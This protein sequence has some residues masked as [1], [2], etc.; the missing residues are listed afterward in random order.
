MQ[1]KEI[2]KKWLLKVGG[3][4]LQLLLFGS[5][6][7][8]ILN[9]GDVGTT[10][11]AMS[12]NSSKH[13]QTNQYV[14]RFVAILLLVGIAISVYMFWRDWGDGRFREIAPFTV[15]MSLGLALVTFFLACD[16]LGKPI[17]TAKAWR[18]DASFA[19]RI[20]SVFWTRDCPYC[21]TT[22]VLKKKT[23]Y[24]GKDW[25]SLGGGSS[26]GDVYQVRYY[27]ECENCKKEIRKSE[28]LQVGKLRKLS[29]CRKKKKK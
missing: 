1:R 15:V 24:Q 29:A 4:F 18:C 3:F 19:E 8:D 6:R 2:A 27:Y 25:I 22:L 5:V 23:S 11:K 21:Q 9:R 13:A 16:V 26:Y 12:P 20:R 28:Y 7:Y 17:A 14:G 10:R